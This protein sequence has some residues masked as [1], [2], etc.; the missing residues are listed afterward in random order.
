MNVVQRTFNEAVVLIGLNNKNTSSS[1]KNKT[2]Q[3][4]STQ[5]H[6]T[7]ITEAD[8][9]LIERLHPLIGGV[10]VGGGKVLHRVVPVADQPEEV[11]LAVE[12]LIDDARTVALQGNGADRLQTLE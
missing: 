2:Y 3:R 8:G 4:L 6:F 1:N 7:Y 11:L 5:L 9:I 10:M 12:A